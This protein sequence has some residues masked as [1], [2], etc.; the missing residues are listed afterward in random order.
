MFEIQS[1][2]DVHVRRRYCVGGGATVNFS[3][4]RRAVGPKKLAAERRLQTNYRRRRRQIG[5]VPG[6]DS[7]AKDTTLMLKVCSQRL[8]KF[9]IL[10]FQKMTP[11]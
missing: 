2:A 11:N 3:R 7:K 4:R 9:K 6:P 5:G 1:R 8:Y 10:R